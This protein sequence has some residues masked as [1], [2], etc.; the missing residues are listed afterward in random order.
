MSSKFAEFLEKNKIDARRVISA[1][2]E[3][4]RLR[5]EDR[6]TRLAKRRAKGADAPPAA[7]GEVKS[8]PTKP[9]LLRPAS[10][11]RVRRRPG[12]AAR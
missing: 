11:F 10:R 7:A 12:W 4:E 6:A 1:S 8:A 5:P 3:L 2:R 9:R